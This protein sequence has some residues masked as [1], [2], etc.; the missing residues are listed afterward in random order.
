MYFLVFFRYFRAAAAGS[1]RLKRGL[2]H[3]KEG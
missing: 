2:K 3:L 1:R